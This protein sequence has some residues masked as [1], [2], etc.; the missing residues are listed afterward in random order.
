MTVVQ[1]AATRELFCPHLVCVVKQIDPGMTARDCIE[2]A[3]KP[4]QGVSTEILKRNKAL[5]QLKTLLQKKSCYS[6]QGFFNEFSSS[7]KLKSVLGKSLNNQMF[8][9]LALQ[10]CE[11]LSGHKPSLNTLQT[12]IIRVSD[13]ETVRQ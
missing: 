10:Y 1:G 12:A 4:T 13:E 7:I 11:A 8:L 2:E 6:E 3:F 9:G 5:E